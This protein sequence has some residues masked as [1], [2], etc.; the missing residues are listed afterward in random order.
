MYNYSF[1]KA[2][3]SDSG[4]YPLMVVLGTA[5]FFIVGMSA[6]A[7]MYYKDLRITPSH[8][9]GVI[10]DWGTEHTDTMTQMLAKRPIGLNAQRYKDI[11][12]EGLGVNHEEWKKGKEAYSRGV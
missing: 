10:Q 12:Q 4:T 1:K 3:L 7:L 9:H 6:N 5:G 8:K 11:Q 2:F